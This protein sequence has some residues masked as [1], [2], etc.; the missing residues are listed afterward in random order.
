MPIP[1]GSFLQNFMNSKKTDGVSEPEVKKTL[2]PFSVNAMDRL[3][4]IG[5]LK[6]KASM[7]NK[8]NGTTDMM[9][10]P[11]QGAQELAQ[12]VEQ[13]EKTAILQKVANFLNKINP[14]DRLFPDNR[15]EDPVSGQKVNP[16]FLKLLQNRPDLR[17]RFDRTG[18]I[19]SDM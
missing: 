10:M 14:F 16:D 1:S 17:E 8:M 3:T 11:S 19:Y 5:S 12:N 7:M 15:V 18:S 6:E 9:G 2:N 13:N 4:S